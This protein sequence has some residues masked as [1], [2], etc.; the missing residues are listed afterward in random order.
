MENRMVKSSQHELEYER[1]RRKRLKAQG[2]CQW[3]RCLLEGRDK[4]YSRCSVCRARDVKTRYDRIR[5][6]REQGFCICGK[7]ITVRKKS[8]VCE[9]CWFKD[10]AKGRTG[11]PKNWLA[12]KQLLQK[13]NYQCAYTRKELII[14]KSASLDHIMPTS[15]GGDNAIENLQWVDLQIN[16]MKRSMSHRE[17]I[18]TIELIL[19]NQPI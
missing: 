5:R 10:M 18:S 6:R 2:L 15:K 7:P 14:G 11:S 8:G 16:F 19:N 9:D 13:Q 3:C 4:A 17:F 12:V 1:N